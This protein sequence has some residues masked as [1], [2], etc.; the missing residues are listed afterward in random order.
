MRAT[1]VKNANEESRAVLAKA[2]DS[3]TTLIGAVF[4]PNHTGPSRHRI[5]AR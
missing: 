5:D 3:F 1:A 4:L 2:R